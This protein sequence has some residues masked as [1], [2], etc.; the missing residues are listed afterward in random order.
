MGSSFLSRSFHGNLRCIVLRGIHGGIEKACKVLMPTLVIILIFL[1][2]R[3]LTLP[4]AME[5]IEFYL[6]PDFTKLA[7]KQF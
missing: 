4:G 1:M 6:K 7:L 2:F 3:S 5:G